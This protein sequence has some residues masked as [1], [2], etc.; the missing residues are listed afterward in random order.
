MKLRQCDICGDDF[1]GRNE[2]AKYCGISCRSEGSRRKQLEAGARYRKQ[3]PDRVAARAKSYKWPGRAEYNKRPSRRA[4][5]LQWSNNDY[6]KKKR[7]IHRVLL[8][9]GCQ[10][11]GYKGCAQ[12]LGFHHRDPNTKK[13]SIS[14][15]SG[16]SIGLLKEEMRKCDILC[17]N[18]HRDIHWNGY[19]EKD[20]NKRWRYTY[21]RKKKFIDRV[22]LKFGC[23][24]CGYK[25]C[26]AALDFHHV[27]REDK[28]F[29]VREK[30]TAPFKVLKA[31]MR[32]CIILCA[33]C[34]MGLD[35]NSEVCKH[36]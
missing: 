17:H 23:S 8:R 18:C 21:I 4:Y 33:N 16:K 35:C 12:V 9:F 36:G 28:E 1:Y 31:E 29:S 25:K 30:T 19:L 3:H 13:F 5:F 26:P 27:S 22:V 10:E 11:C 20:I 2:T 24:E 34:H 32:K 15:C 6:Y 7:F 14:D